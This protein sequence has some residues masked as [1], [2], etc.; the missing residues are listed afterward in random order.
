MAVLPELV[1]PVLFVV[2][3]VVLVELLSELL[4][5]LVVLEQPTKI[6]PTSANVMSNAINFLPFIFPSP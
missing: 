6:V 4:E 5:S 3:V 1:V 2:L